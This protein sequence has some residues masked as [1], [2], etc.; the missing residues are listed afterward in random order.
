MGAIIEPVMVLNVIGI[1]TDAAMVVQVLP[2]PRR[3]LRVTLKLISRSPDMGL[4]LPVTHII[5]AE[6][7]KYGFRFH[8]SAAQVI[9]RCIPTES[10]NITQ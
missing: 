2:N 7:K 9:N 5:R 3:Y 8:A 1:F 6:I 4:P 10:G